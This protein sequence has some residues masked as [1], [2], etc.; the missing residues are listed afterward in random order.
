MPMPNQMEHRFTPQQYTDVI[1]ALKTAIDT[2]NSLQMVQLSPP[3]R[4]K[5][6]AVS[7]NRLPYVQQTI[8]TLAPNYPELQPPYLSLAANTANFEMMEMLRHIMLLVQELNDRYTDFSIASQH[9]AFTYVRHFYA[10]A[11][12]APKGKVVC[13]ALSPLFTRPKHSKL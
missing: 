5:A 13:Q 7:N 3:E 10:S 6:H 8:E 9:N 4:R 11:K 1:N 2:L 12:Q